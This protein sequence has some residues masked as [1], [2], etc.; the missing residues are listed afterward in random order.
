VKLEHVGQR[1]K[2]EHVCRGSDEFQYMSHLF[3][4][5][6]LT[7]D[8]SAV[9]LLI[10]QKRYKETEKPSSLSSLTHKSLSSTTC[11]AKS[12]KTAVSVKKSA[13]QVLRNHWIF[14]L[15]AS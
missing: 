14:L 13:R 1:V 4:T 3:N 5:I 8:R 11:K 15:K 7:E 6:L 10:C 9:D 12:V 2:M